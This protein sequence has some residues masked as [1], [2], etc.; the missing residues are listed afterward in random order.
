MFC[1]NFSVTE[2]QPTAMLHAMK[3]GLIPIIDKDS[4]SFDYKYGLILDIMNDSFN[5][6]RKKLID[7]V[8]SFSWEEYQKQS[9]YIAEFIKNNHN[10]ETFKRQFLESL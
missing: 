10:Y 4:G 3:T 9:K 5:I 2:G 1:I 7:Y 6:T 8:E